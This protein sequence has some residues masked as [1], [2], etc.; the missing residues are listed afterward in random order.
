MLNLKLWHRGLILVLVPLL[1]EVIFVFKMNELLTEAQDEARHATWAQTIVSHIRNLDIQSRGLTD[2]MTR[3]VGFG[4]PTFLNEFDKCAQTIP[5]EFADIKALLKDHQAELKEV[6]DYE[7]TTAEGIS[8]LRRMK[9]VLKADRQRELREPEKVVDNLQLLLQ[10]R[11]DLKTGRRQELFLLL[12]QLKEVGDRLAQQNAELERIWSK[13]LAAVPEKQEENRQQLKQILFGGVVLNVFVAIALALFFSRGIK[14]RLDV[15]KNNSIRLASG[16]PLQ[17][18]LSGDDEIASLDRTFHKVAKI[19]AETMRKERA[20]IDNA[21]DVICTVD[22]NGRFVSMSPS[23]SSVWGYTPEE[24]IGRWYSDIIATN[25]LQKT[26]VWVDETMSQATSRLFENQIVR[27]DGTIADMLW[28]AQWSPQEKSLFCVIHDITDRHEMER[29]KQE[30]VAMVSHDLRTPLNSVQGVLTLLLKG[31]Y[32][33][34][35]ATGVARLSSVDEDV[36]RLIELINDLLDVERLES[37]KMQVLAEPVYLQEVVDR[38][39]E[40]VRTVA[41]RANIKIE[42]A[43]SDAVGIGDRDRLIQVVVNFLSNAIKFSP[44]GAAVTIAVKESKQWIEV[45][46][47]DHGR[48]IPDNLLEGVFERFQ[49][50]KVSDGARNKGTGLGLAICKSI[51]AAHSGEIG[52]NSKEGVGSSFWFRIPAYE[53]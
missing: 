3:Y 9:E 50:V 1:C 4:D 37:G 29:M 44:S 2:N 22:D 11:A 43:E 13:F 46:V 14:R 20:I 41:E 42:P 21:L 51:I 15:V 23:S 26:L 28:S 34:L 18:V 5:L 7:E 32:G 31:V 30:F 49:Q 48:G 45:S 12:M 24:L 53:G 35:N 6:R 17:A 16:Q 47:S 40:A 25:D 52:V 10:M 39:L 8:V 33:E 38:S 36:T 27:K 19:M